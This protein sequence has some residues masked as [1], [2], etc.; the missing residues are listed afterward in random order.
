MDQDFSGQ[1]LAGRSFEG[2]DLTRANFSHADI[3]STNFTNAI[4]VD[5]NF[6]R[7]KAGVQGRPTLLALFG[8]LAILGAVVSGL[9]GTLGT[10]TLVTQLNKQSTQITLDSTVIVIVLALQLL[11]D[12][13]V[14]Q[15]RRNRFFVLLGLTIVVLSIAL[16]IGQSDS[17]LG[18]QASAIFVTT[19]AVDVVL[20]M[21]GAIA[22]ATYFTVSWI[23]AKTWLLTLIA[24]G[25]MVAVTCG[26]TVWLLTHRVI[27]AG[28]LVE[29]GSGENGSWALTWWQGNGWGDVF[30]AGLFAVWGIIAG[31]AV[32][33]KL[34][35]PYIQVRFVQIAATVGTNFRDAD[36]TGAN[37]TGAT[38]PC[39]D[40]TQAKLS[41][42]S[43]HKA[44]SLNL[45]LFDHG[46]LPSE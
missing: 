16:G 37:F 31:A 18:W 17:A 20:F 30:W 46:A 8:F 42:A 7:A 26:A 14:L 29:V 2:L 36:L 44:Q 45:A 3:R 35:F 32:C 41:G 27:L 9:A 15:T 21:L 25:V 24:A 40:F 19:L 6:T 23:V 10:V 12:F 39:T 34:L 28:G 33:N 22:W 13:A 1:N 38:L 5:A 43:W 4:L 11:V